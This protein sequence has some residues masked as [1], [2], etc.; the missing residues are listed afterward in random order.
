MKEGTFTC[1]DITDAV[2]FTGEAP[3]LKF[4]GFKERELAKLI[5]ILQQIYEQN[6]QSIHSVRFVINGNDTEVADTILRNAYKAVAEKGGNHLKIMGTTHDKQPLALA[7]YLPERLAKYKHREKFSFIPLHNVF[8]RALEIVLKEPEAIFESNEK[9]KEEEE[10]IEMQEVVT[11]EEM[12]ELQSLKEVKKTAEKIVESLRLGEKMQ[13]MAYEESAHIIDKSITPDER[14]L[15]EILTPALESDPYKRPPSIDVVKSQLANKMQEKDPELKKE[16]TDIM[17]EASVHIREK[18]FQDYVENFDANNPSGGVF[19]KYQ[20]RRYDDPGIPGLST[21]YH[22]AKDVGKSLRGGG[23]TRKEQLGK[24]Q[25]AL[26]DWKDNTTDEKRDAFYDVLC[27]VEDEIKKEK[28]HA[29]ESGLARL[30]QE[31]KR[32]LEAIDPSL[33]PQKRS[34]SKFDS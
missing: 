9:M 4:S 17:H 10:G 22:L 26:N 19:E 28:G 34:S 33:K 24:I 3:Y 1:I 27:D 32:E 21:L 16:A 12:S 14:E 5:A 25:T 6:Q 31:Y 7:E 15:I 13:R 20:K 8:E 18:I 11:R 2:S 23:E 30:C 29:F